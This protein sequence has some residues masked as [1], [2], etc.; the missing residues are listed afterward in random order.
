MLQKG[1]EQLQSVQLSRN[2]AMEY[3]YL[4]YLPACQSIIGEVAMVMRIVDYYRYAAG[5]EFA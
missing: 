2:V 3:V 1:V 4:K 5:M